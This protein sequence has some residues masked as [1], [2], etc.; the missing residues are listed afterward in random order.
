MISASFGS[1][2]YFT[3][4]TAYEIRFPILKSLLRCCI[5]NIGCAA[6]AVPILEYIHVVARL[7]P[8]PTFDEIFSKGLTRFF[9]KVMKK[10][11]Y[12]AAIFAKPID[13]VLTHPMRQGLVYCAMFGVPIE[14]G[15][16][17]FAEVS[18]KYYCNLFS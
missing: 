7:P 6:L 11:S 15:C 12:I 18:A 8:K 2:C 9:L 10:V 17:R 14:E 4:S 5:L 16:M 3:S 13:I 1:S